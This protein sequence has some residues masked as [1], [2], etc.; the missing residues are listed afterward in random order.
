M[1]SGGADVAS[2]GDMVTALGLGLGLA[3][4]VRWELHE[5]IPGASELCSGVFPHFEQ[6]REKTHRDEGVVL[7]SS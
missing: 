6:S 1:V 2:V 5:Q 4:V 7:G 3:P